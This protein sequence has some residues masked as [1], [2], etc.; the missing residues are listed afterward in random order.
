MTL[1]TSDVDFGI[2]RNIFVFGSNLAGRHGKGSAL[3]ALEKHGAIYG[4]GVGLQGESYGIPTKDGNLRVLG[5][6]VIK[7]HV[8][9]FVKFASDHED[10]MIFH[11]ADVG[12]M[13][14]GYSPSQIG[15]LF[16]EVTKNV[17]FLGD[18][19]H[20]AVYKLAKRAYKSIIHKKLR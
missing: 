13:N 20:F 14:A 18:L 11:V 6:D 8:E 5:I 9:D 3:Y 17:H 2:R 10:E 1:Q 19:R 7:K 4:R 12:C 16:K 15:P